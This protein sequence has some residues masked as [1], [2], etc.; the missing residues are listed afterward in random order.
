MLR[1]TWLSLAVPAALVASETSR[2]L[3]SSELP[4]VTSDARVCLA[5]NCTND[6]QTGH[7]ADSQRSYGVDFTNPSYHMVTDSRIVH[8]NGGFSISTQA[9]G[10][11]EIVA[12]PVLGPLGAE[13]DAQGNNFDCFTFGG[14]S[15]DGIAHM[16]I[17]LTGSTAIG[18]SFGGP[19]V[20][21]A[22]WD[23]ALIQLEVICA[24][25]DYAVGPLACNDPFFQWTASAAIDTTVELSF[26]FTFGVPITVSIAPKTD[27]RLAY[28]QSDKAGSFQGF[29]NLVLTGELL[30]L[31]VTDA[32]GTPIP[33]AKLV[34]GSGYDY[35]HPT[36]EPE[37]AALALVAL[38]ALAWNARRR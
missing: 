10:S 9:S 5:G 8:D 35:L 32:I 1:R 21:P 30:P 14:A 26:P 12:L 20:L 11:Q 2:A 18:W 3:C 29:A 28:Q 33:G 19:Y 24:V 16:P 27:S 25:Y 22:G 13:A 15:G 6:F 7:P 37:A 31:T 36:P 38:A 17:Q 23:P 4:L 34:A